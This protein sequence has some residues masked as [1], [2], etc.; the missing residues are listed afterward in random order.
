MSNPRYNTQTT[1]SREAPKSG[2][3][4]PNAGGSK[5][6]TPKFEDNSKQKTVPIP[7]EPPMPSSSKK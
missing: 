6:S 1:N 5:S 3:N 7:K 2:K 4:N